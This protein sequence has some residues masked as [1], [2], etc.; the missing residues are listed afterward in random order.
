MRGRSLP[1]FLP[2]FP[3]SLTVSHWDLSADSDGRDCLWEWKRSFQLGRF[4]FH[5]LQRFQKKSSLSFI[6]EAKKSPWACNDF[7]NQRENKHHKNQWD[8]FSFKSDQ[9][10]VTSSQ[11]Y[12]KTPGPEIHINSSLSSPS[13]LICR[14]IPVRFHSTSK[15]GLRDRKALN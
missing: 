6:F 1:P 15:K 9:R 12:Y 2:L 10:N 5:L 14:C 7:Q 3:T 4:G 11:V 13:L 8:L